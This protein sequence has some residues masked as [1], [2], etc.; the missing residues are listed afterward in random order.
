MLL[1]ITAALT[2][3]HAPACDPALKERLEKNITPMLTQRAATNAFS[4]VVMVACNGTPVYSIALGYADRARKIPNAVGTRFNLGSMNKMWTAVA[5]A[6]LVEQGKVDLDAPVGRYLPDFP[7]KDVRDN[8][9]VKHLLTHTSGLNT[10]FKRGYLRDHV[11]IKQASDL[12]RFYA[13]DSLDFRPGAKFQYSNAGFATLGMIVERVSGMNYF[14]YM[15][16]N[17]LTRAGMSGAAFPTRPIPAEYAI[18]YATPPGA[19]EATENTDFIEGASPA[20]GAYSDAASVVAFSRALWSGKLVGLPL[21]NQFTTGKVQ[22]GPGIKYAFG[23]GDGSNNGWR[24][25]GHNGGGPGIGAEFLSFPE[26]D[27]D[28]V[29]LTNVEP[30]EAT[31]VIS[32]IAAVITGA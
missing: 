19:T 9:L 29:V 4:G 6:Q 3:T 21:V 14:D 7:N 22:M 26:H 27:I 11:A 12:A 10:Y 24:T 28:V 8:V 20:G 15:R 5:I 16:K 18:G 1:L 2:A 17:V 32:K 13:E 31:T 25:V 23:F 30:P